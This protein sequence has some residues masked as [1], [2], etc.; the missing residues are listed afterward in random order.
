MEKMLPSSIEA[1][2]ALLGCLLIDPASLVQVLDSLKPEHFYREAN[3]LVY[4]AMIRLFNRQEPIELLLLSEELERSGCM[5][6]LGGPGYV[7]QLVNG[8]S[9]SRNIEAYAHTIEKKWTYRQLVAAAGTIAQSSY[10]EEDDALEQAEG[11]VYKIRHG[12]GVSKAV[13]KHIDVLGRY[14]GSLLDLHDQAARGAL[15]GIP[16]GFAKLNKLIGGFRKKK[17]WI[18]AGRPG[19]GKTAAALCIADAGVRSGCNI[20]IF[21]LEMDEEELM[22]RWVAMI[23]KVDSTHLRDGQFDETATDMEGRT[24]WDRVIEAEEEI[25]NLPGKLLIDDTPGN[26]DTAMR[27]K[28]IRMQ[29]EYGLDL[30]I[31]DYL[32]YVK[33]AQDGRKLE[34]RRL[35]VEE[36]SR[37]LKNLAREL[38]VPILA[39]AQLSREVEGRANHRPQLSDLREAGGI[40][41]DCDGAMFLYPDPNRN[42]DDPSWNVDLLIEKHRN[43]ARGVVQLHYIGAYTRFYPRTEGTPLSRTQGEKDER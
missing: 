11:V 22:G 9:T 33:V 12:S 7:A 35:E 43:G 10:S 21:S 31:V 14:M 39:L 42:P 20:L 13:A 3:R 34:N 15:V 27:S 18:L 6:A 17:F 2:I 16:T 4:E 1:E 41:Q 28:A 29:S 23:A 19:D 40:E 38:D 24:E 8:P 5:D 32:Q 36:V 30:I 26:T 25:R 37:N